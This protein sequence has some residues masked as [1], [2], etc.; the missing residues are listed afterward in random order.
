MK[1]DLT[2]VDVVN[3]TARKRFE[4]N[5]DGKTAVTEYMTPGDK[6]IFTHTEVPIG[7]EGNGIASLLAKAA[8]EW[9]KEQ[10]LKV[11]PLCPYV[12]GYIKRHPEW[13][14]FLLEGFRVD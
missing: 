2:G 3:N 13:K 14:A 6:I 1:I 12:A 10:N 4:L 7:L 11:M 5:V 8:L 9:A